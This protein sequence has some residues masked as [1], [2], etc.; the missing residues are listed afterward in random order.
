MAR[1]VGF[2]AMG[3]LGTGPACVP[4]VDLDHRNTGQSGLVRKE[5]DQLPERP[6]GEFV[7]SVFAPSREPLSNPRQIFDDNTAR[8]VFGSLDDRF[9]DNVI[10]VLAEAS[11]L[12][13]DPLELLFRP[14]RIPFLEPLALQIMLAA[15]LLD[16]LAGIG[17]AV[18]VGRD[19]RDAEVDADEVGRRHGGGVGDVDGHEQE[20]FAVRP[21][22][23]VG[24]S[25]GVGERLGLVLPHHDRDDHTSFERQEADPI[26]PLERHHPLIEGHR[27]VGSEHRPDRLVSPV[28]FARLRDAADGRLSRETEPPAEVGVVK[29]LQHDL[30]RDLNVKCFARQPVGGF[31][32][33]LDRR[34]E[35]GGVVAVGQELGLQRQLHTRMIDNTHHKVNNGG[36]AYL[37]MP[38]GRGFAP[39]I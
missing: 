13:R 10:D 20:P 25:L 12:A 38:E 34:L 33:P 22:N 23:E 37:P 31:V 2:L 32:E 14:L 27:G 7:A 35:S 24:L 19:V 28:R 36:R 30:I 21:Q 18:A 5:R 11:F 8:G 1:P 9:R 39:A 29:S 4:G 16:R 6:T 15:N 3:A 17:V 26:D